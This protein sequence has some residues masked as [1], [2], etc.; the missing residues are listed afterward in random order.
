RIIFPTLAAFESFTPAVFWWPYLV[1]AASYPGVSPS[2]SDDVPPAWRA[3]TEF[4]LNDTSLGVF[5]QDHWQAASPLSVTYGVRYDLEFYPSQ[6]ITKRDLNNVQPRA[7]AAYAYSRHGVVRAGYGIFSDRLAGSVGQ[8]FNATA[9]GSA[10]GLANTQRLFPTVA[11][12][13]GIFRQAPGGGRD[14]RGGEA[15][16]ARHRLS[17]QLHALA[18]PQQRR[19]ARQPRRSARGNGHRRR[20][21]AVTAGCQASIHADGPERAAG[22]GR[23]GAGREG[24]RAGLGGERAAVQHLCRPRFQS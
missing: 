12:V 18:R 21:D 7:G 6:Y 13:T 3:A 1:T 8:L 11:A 4:G 5:V 22:G 16:R 20:D 10:G 14:V 17:R 2:W 19:F 15:V 24:E 9:W 23:R